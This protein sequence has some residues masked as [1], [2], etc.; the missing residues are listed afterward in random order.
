ME[1][2]LRRLKEIQSDGLAVE[3][4]AQHELIQFIAEKQMKD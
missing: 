2:A 3:E 1:E 4:A